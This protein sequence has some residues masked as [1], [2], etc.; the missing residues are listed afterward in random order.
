MKVVLGIVAAIVVVAALFLGYQYVQLQQAAVQWDDA[1]EILSESIEQED[2]VWKVRLQAIIDEPIDLVWE[3]VQQPERSAEY[4]DSF[5]KSELEKQ[6]GNSKTVLLQ[7]QVLTLPVQT[8]IMKFTFDDETK[9]AKLT[10][11][12]SAAQDLTARYHLKPS[13]DGKKTLFTYE[14]E[15]EAKINVPLPVSAQ[16]GAFKEIFVKTI[17][18]IKKGIGEE[19]AKAAKAAA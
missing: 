7:V 4:V 10:T 8:Q 11:V 17:R 5:K 13:P 9:S 3:A 15:A 18:A 14:A 16:K 12:Q 6:E 2:R 19:K 1:K